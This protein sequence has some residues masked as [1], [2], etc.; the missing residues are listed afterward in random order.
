MHNLLTVINLLNGEWR[1]S[2]AAVP[3]ILG[4]ISG[5]ELAWVLMIF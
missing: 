1:N 2:I 4:I 5:G 3:M